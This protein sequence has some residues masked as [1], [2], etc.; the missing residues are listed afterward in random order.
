LGRDTVIT[1]N[2]R[3]TQNVRRY[4]IEHV[5]PA[6]RFNI[7]FMD[8]VRNNVGKTLGDAGDFWLQ[9]KSSSGA[10]A[11]KPHNQFNQYAR[12]FIADNPDL[13]MREA[14]RYWALKRALPFDT[15]RHHYERSDLDLDN[16]S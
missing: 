15:G 3:N 1:D 16:D 14:R 11:I 5:D 2:Y 13:G 7:A 8:W 12:D 10:T 4:F 6:F 9:C